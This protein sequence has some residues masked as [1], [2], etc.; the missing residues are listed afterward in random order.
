MSLYTYRASVIKVVDADTVDLDVDL[1]FD[2]HQFMRVRLYGINAPEMRTQEGKDAR[3]FLLS[4]MPLDAEVL[5]HSVKDKR[6]KYGR[7]L[8][9]LEYGGVIINDELVAN[10]HAVE[11]MK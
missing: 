7:Y 1:G 6:D 10:E 9:T 5:M 11:Y 2:I 3:D 4:I 8:A